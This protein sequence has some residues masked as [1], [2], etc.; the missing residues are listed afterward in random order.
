MTAG[1]AGHASEVNRAR[2]GGTGR[3]VERFNR[4]A[5]RGGATANPRGA[6]GGVNPAIFFNNGIPQTPTNGAYAQQLLGMLTG[7]VPG[8]QFGQQPGGQ[9]AAGVIPQDRLVRQEVLLGTV[10]E[11]V[12]PDTHIML[13]LFPFLEV[14]TDEVVFNYARGL[15]EG[16]APA[17][18]QG[19]EA[20]LVRS[21]DLFGGE[22]RASVL[23]WAEKNHYNE[24]DVG[25]GRNWL[26]LQELV[27]SGV[28]PLTATSMIE[29]FNAKVS[30]DTIRRQNELNNRIEWLGA[31]ALYNN[32]ITYNANGMKFS[33]TF[34]RPAEN[35]FSYA[36]ANIN[37]D[38]NYP[39]GDAWTAATS[40]PILDGLS[41]VQYVY[42]RYNVRLNRAIGS[43]KIWNSIFRSDK[44]IA[45]S[46]LVTQSGSTDVD[47]NYV[48]DG[49]G[50]VAAMQVWQN[51]TGIQPVVYDSVYRTRAYGGAVGDIAIT[52][53]IP[54]N[55]LIFLPD[56]Q[57]VAQFDDTDLGLGRFLTSP[58]PAGNWTPGF[59]AWDKDLGVDPWGYDIG[60]GI[61]TFPVLP[62]NDL[63]VV[64]QP[65][66]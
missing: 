35:S 21:D 62:H 23:D 53:F 48:F 39:I 64:Y 37:G 41:I 63:T 49:W 59:Y 6:F 54:D 58:H 57:D 38:A 27:A 30:D 43:R 36:A 66:A 26:L 22:G 52:R 29:D 19:A 16:L 5:S 46:G 7:Q 32:Q 60:T 18:A 55:L 56:P 40:D 61:K 15:T 14:P 47:L 45:R 2:P 50:P 4:T 33:V 24:S 34:D 13:Q 8:Q 10:R 42:D 28:L 25:R 20:A 51:A 3:R 65:I 9:F 11:L 44:F 12:A 31:Q 1:L 17:R